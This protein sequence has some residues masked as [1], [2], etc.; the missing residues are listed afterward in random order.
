MRLHYASY[1]YSKLNALSD[2]FFFKRFLRMYQLMSAG[3]F[4]LH[5]LDSICDL[6]GGAWRTA[7]RRTLRCC[8]L[9]F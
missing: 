3:D 5:S 1:K 4:R 2:N 6:E 7:G 8:S 9:G